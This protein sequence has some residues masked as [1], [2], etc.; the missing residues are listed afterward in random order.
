MFSFQQISHPDK[1]THARLGKITTAHGEI[2][3]PVFMPV[4]TKGTVKAMTP[5]GLKILNA[6]IILGNTYHLYLRPGHELVRVA[7][8]LHRFMAW[9]KPI[10]TDSGGFQ[11]YSL[12]KIRKV[13]QEGVAFQSHIDG[14]RHVLTPELSIQ[15]QE[16]LG[17]DIMMCFDE[18]PALPADRAQIAKSME[19][20]LAWEERSLKA[21]VRQDNALF[22]IV[23]GGTE[24]T[25]RTQCLAR[26]V[27]ISETSTNG[28]SFE[29]YALGGLSVGEPNEVMH[30]VVAHIAPL[31]P[32][33][34]PRYLMGVGTPEDLVT[35]VDL[36]ID[37]F[38][39]VMPTRNARNGML[40]TDTGDLQIK[41]AAFTR[42]FSPV[43]VGCSCY[44]CQNFSRAYLR[45]LY[46]S[47]EI[48]AS[49][50]N[51]IH[52]LHYYIGL[53]DQCRLN[54]RDGTFA[55]FKKTFFGKR[56]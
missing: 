41:Q 19:L 35:C 7:G 18:C 44:T 38:D 12:T 25:L 34:K 10:L 2:Q 52:N 45:H 51:T 43:M 8:G 50:L 28:F 40:F 17:A 49:I 27:E 33:N 24:K 32:Q 56:T 31:M 29:G 21:R 30:E 22:A 4:G 9:D 42:D 15:I 6:Q 54:L 1:N 55:S 20:T 37:M 23:Q 39:C 11:V 5:E 48:L 47:D 16:A 26:L 46:L 53:L 14:S 36:G 3:T 13:T